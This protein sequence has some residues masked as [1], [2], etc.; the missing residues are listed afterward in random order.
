MA[1]MLVQHQVS[2]FAKW[3]AVYDSA[4]DLRKSNGELSDEIYRDADDPNSITLLFKWD[5]LERAKKYAQSPGLK[6]AM[7][8]A[9]VTRPP[10]ISFLN[11]A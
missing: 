10:K 4:V 11:E 3:K 9:G 7:Q 5:S 8:K 2:D 6:E 1:T